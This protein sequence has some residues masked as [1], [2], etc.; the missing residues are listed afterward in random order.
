MKILRRLNVDADAL[1]QL[2]Q[3]VDGRELLLKTGTQS[4]IAYE[5][6]FVTLLAAHGIPH[7]HCFDHAALTQNQLLMEYIPGSPTLHSTMSPDGCRL[8]GE[9]VRKIHLVRST[10]SMRILPDG[11]LAPFAWKDFVN[12]QLTV[13]RQR[14][15]R[16]KSLDEDTIQKVEGVVGCLDL[17]PSDG[18]CLI[19]G[20]LHNENVMQ[21]GPDMVVFDK[22]HAMLYGVALYDLATIFIDRIG[23]N[24]HACL[25]EFQDG[26]QL[27]IRKEELERYMVLR[28][29]ERIPNRFESHSI[30]VLNTLLKRF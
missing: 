1:L 23:N 7:I 26:Y 4:E 11:T 2:V 17:A 18:Y 16:D 21:K 24:Q 13:N 12:E 20:D 22:G 29:Y 14:H 10:G 9:S 25:N 6:H 27:E 3:M 5:K 19:H 28:C 8:W 30:R 15:K